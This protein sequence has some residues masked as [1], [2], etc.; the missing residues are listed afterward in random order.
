MNYTDEEILALERSLD[1]VGQSVQVKLG[2]VEPEGWLVKRE[3]YGTQQSFGAFLLQEHGMELAE[4][5]LQPGASYM[6]L[7]Q[8]EKM[9]GRSLLTI[10]GPSVRATTELDK[11]TKKYNCET[12]FEFVG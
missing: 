10:E 6:L 5:G 12:A 3:E 1:L 2:L 4:L 11:L 7:P 9:I 8:G